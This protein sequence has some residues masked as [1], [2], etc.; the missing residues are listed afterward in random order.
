MAKFELPNRS[1]SVV[2]DLK[3][4]VVQNGVEEDRVRLEN[5]LSYGYEPFAVTRNG[6]MLEYHL[7]KLV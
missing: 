5:V 7:R 6:Y 4:V 1:A 3:T 2:W